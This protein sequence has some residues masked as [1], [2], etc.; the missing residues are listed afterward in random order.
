M[1]M[2]EKSPAHMA[3]KPSTA[4]IIQQYFFIMTYRR[5]RN[6]CILQTVISHKKV[7]VA[8][9]HLVWYTKVKEM[10]GEHYGTLF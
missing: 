10:R 1:N 2:K 4:A 8:F 6:T 5:K 7:L 3:K 9:S